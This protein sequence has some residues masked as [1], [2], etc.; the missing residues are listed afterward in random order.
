MVAHIIFA[1]RHGIP[2]CKFRAD[3]GVVLS[4]GNV[5]KKNMKRKGIECER[6]IH[7]NKAV[8]IP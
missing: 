5:T 7:F 2:L 4:M 6:S 3:Q 1:I 8:I